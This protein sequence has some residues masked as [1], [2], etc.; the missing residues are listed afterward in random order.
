M[1]CGLCGKTVEKDP[2]G[3]R[4]TISRHYATGITH[5]AKALCDECGIQLAATMR[6]QPKDKGILDLSGRH[7]IM[8]RV[9]TAVEREL[10]ETRGT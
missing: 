3:Y 7:N 5:D 4:I 6:A 10:F 9:T 1:D 8:R 2:L